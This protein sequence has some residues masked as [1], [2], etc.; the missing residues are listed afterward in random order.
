MIFFS[1]FFHCL[2]KTKTKRKNKKNSSSSII[3][4]GPY[5]NLQGRA[6]NSTAQYI[7]VVQ[8]SPWCA[9]VVLRSIF[10]VSHL[11]HIPLLPFNPL[12]VADTFTVYDGV[13]HTMLRVCAVFTPPWVDYLSPCYKCAVF[14]PPPRSIIYHHAARVP[15]YEASCGVKHL[16]A[17]HLEHN[18]P[19]IKARFMWPIR[20]LYGLRRC[21]SHTPRSILHGR[22]DISTAVTG[23]VSV[24]KTSA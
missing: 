11:E 20:Y 2:K 21:L 8:V 23:I 3:N 12:H 5:I 1:C 10:K 22:Y 9:C 15:Y 19:T 18:S 13:Y 4:D 16:P 14:T 6:G 17:L 24:S 7:R